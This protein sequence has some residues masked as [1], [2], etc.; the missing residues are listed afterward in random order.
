MVPGLC[1]MIHM[2]LG[3]KPLGFVS[4][5][6]WIVAAEDNPK[7]FFSLQNRDRTGRCHR[8]LTPRV[9]HFDHEKFSYNDTVR[10]DAAP[11]PW[12]WFAGNLL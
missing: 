9:S 8:G 3:A 12:L 6:H 5:E 2:K 11:C 1:P 10:R 4:S 7:H